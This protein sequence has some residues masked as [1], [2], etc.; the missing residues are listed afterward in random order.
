MS[1]RTNPPTPQTPPGGINRH[2]DRILDDLRDDPYQLRKKLHEPTVCED[3]GALYRHGHWQRGSAPPDA[4]RALCPACHRMHDHMPVGYV[5]LGGA[6][7]TAH[8]DEV[9]RLV[10]H[11]AERERE[12]HA[13]ARIMDVEHEADHTLVTTTDIHSPQRIGEALQGAYHGHLDVTYGRGDYSVR[14]DWRR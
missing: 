12:E 2:G 3:C 7:F 14:V 9:M 6:F 8:R 4:Q 1:R 13:L 10:Q 11:E 5:T